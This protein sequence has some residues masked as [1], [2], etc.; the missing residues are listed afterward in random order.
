MTWGSIKI[1]LDELIIALRHRLVVITYF[2]CW[3]AIF[4]FRFRPDVPYLDV[5][6]EILIFLVSQAT[7][8]LSL[9]LTVAI[10]ARLQRGP[11]VPA[12]YLS[13]VV[14][15][16]TLIGS[17]FMVA[18]YWLATGLL[19]FDLQTMLIYAFLQIVVAEL[20]GSLVMT[21]FLPT[22]LRDLRGGA[23]LAPPAQQTDL[24]QST[25][26]KEALALSYA[27]ASPLAA[28]P[29]AAVATGAVT[30][31]PEVVFAGKRVP[32]QDVRYVRTAGNYLDVTLRSEKLFVQA[33]MRSFLQQMEESDGLLLHRSL[34]LSLD[35]VTS[36][37]RQGM[38][39]LVQTRDG[40]AVKTARS[41][42]SE[43][44]AWLKLH[45]VQR[46]TSKG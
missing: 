14:F 2:A 29:R 32:K 46:I 16:G 31:V 42:Q 12:V 26:A 27:D 13:P 45:G 11:A 17:N 41:R 40:E 30:V 21:L 10:A 23:D 36:Y 9:P 19:V 24:P 20:V 25:A 43:V 6:R 4:P 22:I 5:W 15:F 8:I 1:T 28:L 7:V 37:Q 38:E 18:S 35:E 44:L 39:I 33:T 34:W 3:A